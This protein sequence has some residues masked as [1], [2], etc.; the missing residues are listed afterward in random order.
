MSASAT[1]RVI[2]YRKAGILVLP[3][4]F[5]SVMSGYSVADCSSQ[6]GNPQLHLVE[7]YSSEGCDSCPPAEKWMSSL[8]TQ[9]GIAGLEFH[10]DYWDS[11]QWRDPFSNHAYTARQEALAKA[12]NRSQYYTPQI[13]LDGQPWRNWPKGTP[14]T[15]V[16]NTSS[17]L[18]VKVAP[19]MPV[20]AT[21]DVQ[22]PD[23]KDKGKYRLYAAVTENGL[24]RSV[25]GGENKGKKLSHDS[26][27]RAFV[28][29]LQTPHAEVELKLPEGVDLSRTNVVG[30]LQDEHDDTV[31]DVVRVTLDKCQNQ[32]P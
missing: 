13:W 7:L 28:G 16:E 11:M 26:V 10:V 29:P 21:F 17:A 6:S 3:S 2:L 19:G 14:P 32:L 27:V 22:D 20:R 30:F 12:T 24:T 25:T 9:P 18:A 15:P 23:G 5:I 31:I 1:T 4:I 8:L